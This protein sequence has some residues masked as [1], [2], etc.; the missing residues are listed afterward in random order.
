MTR[1]SRSMWGMK[2]VAKGTPAL[3]GGGGGVSHLSAALR[4]LQK[5]LHV[6]GERVLAAER[7]CPLAVCCSLRFPSPGPAQAAW[8]MQK[9]PSGFAERL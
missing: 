2:W 9:F 8:A 5:V 3:L 6:L 4:A 1:E 7:S